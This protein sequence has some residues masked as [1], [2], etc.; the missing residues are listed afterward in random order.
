M[1]FQ[2]STIVRVQL[3]VHRLGH[4]ALYRPRLASTC[5]RPDCCARQYPGLPLLR[6][7]GCAGNAHSLPRSL[8][9]RTATVPLA[10]QLPW[11]AMPCANGHA[12]GRSSGYT[13]TYIAMEPRRPAGHAPRQGRPGRGARARRYGRARRAHVVARAAYNYS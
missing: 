12:N 1:I 7:L 8:S 11:P 9:P 10:G 3:H 4:T 2:P 13:D 5:T 6:G